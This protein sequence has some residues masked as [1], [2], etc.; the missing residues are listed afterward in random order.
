[1]RSLAGVTQL[2]CTLVLSILYFSPSLQV[3]KGL[4][5]RM[6]WEKQYLKQSLFRSLELCGHMQQNNVL[7]F[8]YLLS[9][10]LRQ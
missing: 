2:M 3:G 9:K 5:E 1:M 4:R 7:H 8:C 6:H 10:E